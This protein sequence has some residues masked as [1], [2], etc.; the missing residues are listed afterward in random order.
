MGRLPHGPARSRRS[1]RRYFTRACVLTMQLR[2][3]SLRSP[4]V[5]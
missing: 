4:V 3:R 1:T 2:P 5:V